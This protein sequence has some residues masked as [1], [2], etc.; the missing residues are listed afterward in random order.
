ML[1]RLARYS[2]RVYCRAGVTYLKYPY[3]SMMM[4]MMM[5]RLLLLTLT[6]ILVLYDQYH[7]ETSPR[8]R[9]KIYNYECSDYSFL[10]LIGIK[11]FNYFN[12]L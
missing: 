9:Y 6:D 7:N 11:V 8:L 4:M 10:S 5:M 2:G 1:A 3:L 12:V